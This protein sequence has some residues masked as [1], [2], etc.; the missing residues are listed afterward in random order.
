MV[1]FSLML[2]LFLPV[3]GT[4]ANI[5]IINIVVVV[6]TIIV[7]IIIV[8]GDAVILLSLPNELIRQT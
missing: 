3:L 6:V 2:V 8:F 1:L 7:V 5:M 4:D